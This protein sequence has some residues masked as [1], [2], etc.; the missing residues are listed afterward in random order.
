MKGPLV[1]GALARAGAA[2]SRE[3]VW[4]A[5]VAG[6]VRGAFSHAGGTERLRVTD[7]FVVF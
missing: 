7:R 6:A 2:G 1:G 3:A 5:A 4:S